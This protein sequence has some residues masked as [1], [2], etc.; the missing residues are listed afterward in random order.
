MSV[1]IAVLADIH[2]NYVALERCVEFALKRGIRQFL[3][4]GD[5]V[6]EFA[7]PER[8]MELLREYD[9]SYDCLFIRGNKEDYW[10]GYRDGGERGWKEYGSTTGA[11]YYAYHR[12]ED[13]DLAFF[14]GLPVS[15]RLEYGNLP[16]LLACHGSP[17]NVKGQLC[18]SDEETKNALLAAG[19]NCVLHGHSHIQGKTVYDGRI[20]LNPGSVGL[21][22]KAE[23]KAQFA[24]LHGETDG[25]REELISLDYDR[26]RVIRELC[27]SGLTERAPYWCL[28]TEYLLRGRGGETD[29]GHADVLFRAMELC[30]QKNGSCIWP[31]IPEACWEQAAWEL[32]PDLKGMICIK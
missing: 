20:A 26:E 15:R 8:T 17:G 14:E 3:F 28:V 27:E 10:L 2:S 9:A 22:L 29:I 16:P 24:I 13:R 6:G 21:A 18:L 1:E 32:L 23:G 31:D 19:A 4:L 25:F 7:W 5:Y 30:R 11:L 12:L